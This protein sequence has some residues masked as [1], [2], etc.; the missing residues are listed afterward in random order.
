M[1]KF[2]ERLSDTIQKIQDLKMSCLTGEKTTYLRMYYYPNN[3]SIF[4]FILE[5]YE[6][7]YVIMEDAWNYIID[8]TP[9]LLN[10]D[11]IHIAHMVNKKFNAF[12][13]DKTKCIF[14]IYIDIPDEKLD[15]PKGPHDDPV[16]K[17]K[18]TKER[19]S[20]YKDKLIDNHSSYAKSVS[21]DYKLFTRDNQYE[22]FFN[23]YP[24]LSEYDVINLYKIYLLDVLSQQYDLV[25]YVDLDVYFTNSVD[26]FS[27]L[28]AES[29]LCCNI[30]SGIEAGVNLKN[31]AYLETYD[32]DFRNP[33]SKYWNAHAL[34]VEEDL[35]GDNDVF[36]TGIVMASRKVMEKLDYF[37][38]MEKTISKMKELK[39]FSMYPQKIQQA[40]GYD[41]ETIMSYKVKK[42]SIPVYKLEKM[43]HHKHD[44]N[45]IRS[46]EV[47]SHEFNRAK[48]KLEIDIEKEN[49]QMIH[50]ISK[51]FGLVFG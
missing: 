29:M 33:Q 40:F 30:S 28:P 49:I 51:N 44:Y 13:N 5:K 9:K 24:D 42:N 39:E 15:N 7:P 36:N 10:W 38:G 4:S 41:N 14:S 46:Y 27:W 12:F 21:A 37:T 6:I 23:R 47:G 2:N 26:A 19:L 22:E 25:L 35:D 32:K 20:Q 18:R 16:N 1:I 48:N 8:H 34:L 3:E 31:P 11:D 45:S 43:W 17:S 50:F